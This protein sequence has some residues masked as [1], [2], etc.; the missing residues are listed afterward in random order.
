MRPAGP[1]KDLSSHRIVWENKVWNSV[2]HA[3]A[4]EWVQCSFV[5]LC[6]LGISLD[7]LART[8]TFRCESLERIGLEGQTEDISFHYIPWNTLYPFFFFTI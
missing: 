7:G 8:D 4:A 3:A 6:M 1:D 2:V 5:F